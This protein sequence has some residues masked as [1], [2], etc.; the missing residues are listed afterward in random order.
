MPIMNVHIAYLPR[1]VKH[2]DS[3]SRTPDFQNTGFRQHRVFEIRG[4]T[5]T[6][7]AKS[8]LDHRRRSFSSRADPGRFH[9]LVEQ[10]C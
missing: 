1:F 10:F 6:A 5:W 2:F 8:P 9:V 3:I 7:V 4:P